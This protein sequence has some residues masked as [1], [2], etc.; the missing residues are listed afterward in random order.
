VNADLRKWFDGS[1]KLKRGEYTVEGGVGT[2]CQLCYALAVSVSIWSNAWE[3]GDQKR[4][5][6]TVC[7]NGFV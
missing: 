5:V 1:G 4:V 3:I 6:G 2:V 7:V